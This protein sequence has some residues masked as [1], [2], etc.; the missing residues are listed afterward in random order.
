MVKFL[1]VHLSEPTTRI[2]ARTRPRCLLALSFAL[3]AGFAASCRGPLVSAMEDSECSPPCW[4]GIVPGATSVEEA[5]HLLAS[6]ADVDPQTVV[7]DEGI[8]FRFTGQVSEYSADLRASGGTITMIVF[9]ID[10]RLP[11]QRVLAISGNPSL[12]CAASWW[13]DHRWLSVDLVNPED[14]IIVSYHRDRFPVEGETATIAADDL[15][16][17]VTF[18]DPMAYRELLS[19]SRLTQVPARTADVCLTPWSGYGTFHV[20]E[21]LDR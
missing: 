14:G 21:A 5:K 8:S 6:M 18:F 13:S 17:A 4:R 1:H 16:D 20:S 2:K 9:S 15:V 3:L 12:V 19:A 7:A 11:L 10:R